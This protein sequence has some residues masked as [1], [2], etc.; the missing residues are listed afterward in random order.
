MSAFSG[1]QGRGA[2]RR[3]KAAKHE[4][5]EERNSR[6]PVERTRKYRLTVEPVLAHLEE[7]HESA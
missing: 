5:A 3:L 1:P 7:S 4:E 6:T 2:A